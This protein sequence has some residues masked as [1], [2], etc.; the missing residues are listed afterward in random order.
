M[1]NKK[2]EF[3]LVL[4][5][6]YDSTALTTAQIKAYQELYNQIWIRLEA[7]VLKNQEAVRNVEKMLD[8]YP[9]IDPKASTEYTWNLM[10]SRV[11]LVDPPREACIINVDR[12]GKE[13]SREYF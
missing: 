10:A 3:Q 9:E 11:E 7:L 8:K 2:V 12:D 6:Q 1:S 4:K 13:I 5:E